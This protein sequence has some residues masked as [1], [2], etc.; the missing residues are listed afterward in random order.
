[1]LKRILPV[2][3]VLL[4]CLATAGTAFAD[5]GYTSV[6]E[7]P[8][9]ADFSVRVDFDG[10]GQPH[11]VTDYP[12]ESAGATEM[13]LVYATKENPEVF[14]LKY[15]PATGATAVGSWNSD[16]FGDARPAE[17]A[18]RMIRNGEVSTDGC[19][20]ISTSNYGL[21]TDWVLVYS[22]PEKNYT[23][24]KERTY[25]QA[26]NAMGNGGTEKAIYYRNGK[27]ESARLLKRTLDADLVVEYDA[28][29]KITYASVTRYGTETRTY[30][31]DPSTGLFSGHSLNELGFDEAD[32]TAEPLAAKGLRTETAAARPVVAARS[33]RDSSIVFAGSMLV[34]ILIGLALFRRFQR[35]RNE[36]KEQAAREAAESASPAPEKAAAAPTPAPEEYPEV[37]TMSSSR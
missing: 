30:D 2:F 11:V 33:E 13:N 31:Y 7:I 34:G 3:A 23:E 35:R 22:V 17:E 32:L 10:D 24:Y 9:A 37:K 26:F 15:T 16:V 19:V 14:T 21:E 27:M 18:Y 4:I 1:M 5:Y 20:Y 12:F 29:G 8:M 28:Y 25:A 6:S 36:R